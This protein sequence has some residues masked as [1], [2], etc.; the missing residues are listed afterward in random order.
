MISD[1]TLFG[2]WYDNYV[3]I[4]SGYGLVPSGIKPQPGPMLTHV[5]IAIWCH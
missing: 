1:F 2:S 3:N 5:C 4:G